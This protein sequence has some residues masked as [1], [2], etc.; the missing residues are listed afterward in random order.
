MI[1]VYLKASAID[2][3]YVFGPDLKSYANTFKVG[4]HDGLD[5]VM[6]ATDDAEGEYLA[7]CEGY[8]GDA[9]ALKVNHP[10]I[11]EAVLITENNAQTDPVQFAG[12]PE[13]VL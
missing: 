5:V 11:A 8:L 7:A 6:V 9:A 4:E 12:E 3:Q 2:D 13:E 10:E 1:K